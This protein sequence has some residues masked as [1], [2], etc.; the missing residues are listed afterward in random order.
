MITAKLTEHITVITDRLGVNLT[1]I[2]GD[3]KA[4]LVDTGYGLDQIAP[5]LTGLTDLP[6]QV[7]LT[8][9][10][11]DH[12]LGTMQFES[13]WAFPEEGPV[14][15][16]YTCRERRMKILR[17]AGLSPD[18]YAWYLDRPM[19]ALHL[20]EEGSID[21]GDVHVD[22]M[23]V[24]GHTPGSAMMYIPEDGVLVSGDNWNP[25]TWLFFPEALPLHVYKRNV[26]RV[27]ERPIGSVICSHRQGLFE[28]T[29]LERFLAGIR[30]TAPW[31]LSPFAD[32]PDIRRGM[33]TLDGDQVIAFDVDK[34]DFEQLDI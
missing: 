17:N 3:E 15:A 28:R 9:A 4:V 20:L 18:A 7:I 11:H 16:Q 22:V 21:L 30:A 31:Q 34:C 23:H 25:E 26:M 27:L 29:R 32:L 24:P 13:V 10:H 14:Y 1:L 8:H 19:P 12:A 6:V 2:T 5:V 33:M